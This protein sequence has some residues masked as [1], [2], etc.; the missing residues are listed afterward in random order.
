MADH[1]HAQVSLDGAI[2]P[3]LEV[4][5]PQQPLLI[6][7][8]SFDVPAREG[9]MQHAFDRRGGRGVGDE[10]F[11]LAG[12]WMSR[13]DQPYRCRWHGETSARAFGSYIDAKPRRLSLPD[14]RT[15]VAVFNVEVLPG[16]VT[17]EMGIS[18]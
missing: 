2:T 4:V 9:H 11:D 15:L 8:A 7:K 5:E 14:D 18:A 17:H 3:A 1:R 12:R 10:V 13:N 16:L 6:L